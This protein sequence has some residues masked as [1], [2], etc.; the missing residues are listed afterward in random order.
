LGSLENAPGRLVSITVLAVIAV[1]LVLM[2]V[3]KRFF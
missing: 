2:L 3:L 1:A